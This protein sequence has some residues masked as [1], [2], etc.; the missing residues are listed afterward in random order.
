MSS[1]TRTLPDA[2]D[3][4]EGQPLSWLTAYLSTTLVTALNIVAT[5]GVS[6][7]LSR[8]WSKTDFLLFTTLNRYLSLLYC[9]V[10]LSLGFGVVQFYRTTSM[11]N[12][13]RVLSNALLITAVLAAITTATVMLN[14]RTLI[15]FFDNKA[16]SSYWAFAA[17]CLWVMAQAVYHVVLSY[18]RAL[19]NTRAAN[20]LMFVVKT[21]IVLC[22]GALAWTSQLIS[23]PAYYGYVG[24]AICVVVAVEIYRLQPTWVLSANDIICRELSSISW[25]RAL[26]SILRHAMMPIIATILYVVGRPEIAGGIVVVAMLLRGIESL[27][28]PLVLMVLAD[29]INASSQTLAHSRRIQLCWDCILLTSLPTVACLVFIAESMLSVWLG[30]SYQVLASGF[31]LISLALPAVL[32]TVLLRGNLESRYRLSPLAFTSLA[33]IVIVVAT[34]AVLAHLDCISLVSVAA[35]IAVLYWAQF[36]F[37]FLL[38]KRE[39]GTVLFSTMF[40]CYCWQKVKGQED[41]Q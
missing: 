1:A 36:S 8:A 33:R 11:H 40:C 32:G 37:L 31:Q 15:D 12:K 41:Q 2:I 27:F 39:F 34:L 26:E 38:L 22:V 13:K 4:R 10:S 24:V 29:S 21:L 7:I 28:Q 6:S 19:G 5:L 14:S 3:A 16:L 9:V 23:V 20:T 25:S 17:A 35:T 18:E 30:D